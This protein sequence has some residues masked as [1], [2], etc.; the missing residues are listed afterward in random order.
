MF[1]FVALSSSVSRHLSCFASKKPLSYSWNS[2]SNSFSRSVWLSWKRTISAT[3]LT[4]EDCQKG[5]ASQKKIYIPKVER[6]EQHPL[7]LEVSKISN[8][9]S[10][11]SLQGCTEHSIKIWPSCVYR[12]SEINAIIDISGLQWVFGISTAFKLVL[13]CQMD[14]CSLE[15]S[16]I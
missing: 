14:A 1:I 5:A 4:K 8:I 10:F 6:E 12:S 11:V 7:L 2:S 9:G 13:Y 3:F 16:L 15:Y